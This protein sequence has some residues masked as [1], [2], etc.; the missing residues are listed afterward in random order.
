MIK[1]FL[2]TML[3]LISLIASLYAKDNL[4]TLATQ[5]AALNQLGEQYHFGQGVPQDYTKARELYLKAVELGSA[6]AA[7]HLGRLYINGEGVQKN[8][9]EAGKWYQKSVELDPS[10]ENKCMNG[11]HSNGLLCAVVRVAMQGS[12]PGEY[13][14]GKLYEYGGLDIEI[15]LDKAFTLYYRAAKKGYAPAALFLASCYKEGKGVAP[16]AKKAQYWEN[17]YKEL[18]K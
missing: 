10:L 3:V 6:S 17:Q 5:A 8:E 15:D 12:A 9:E 1:N 14:L 2:L 18:T 11:Q 16:D 7:N 4:D 13:E